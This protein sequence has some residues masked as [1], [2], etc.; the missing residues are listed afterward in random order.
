[1]ATVII[2]MRDDDDTDD[3]SEADFLGLIWAYAHLQTLARVDLTGT[4]IKHVPDALFHLN[5]VLERIEFPKTLQTVGCRSFYGALKLRA[6]DFSSCFELEAIK[7]EAFKGCVSLTDLKFPLTSM[8]RIGT[9]AFA[10]CVKLGPVVFLP[11]SV[12]SVGRA[13]GGCSALSAIIPF[14]VGITPKE[15]PLKRCA[16]RTLAHYYWHLNMVLPQNFKQGIKEFGLAL[17]V[18]NARNKNFPGLP[19]ELIWLVLSFIN[20]S[21]C[22]R[23][24]GSAICFF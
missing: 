14:H 20:A 11:Y 5:T 4:V 8:G 19:N 12:L 1:M 2:P 18:A 24:H 17:K 9:E 23:R 21:E 13:F 22:P 3:E 16:T 7:S 10:N 15:L 6:V